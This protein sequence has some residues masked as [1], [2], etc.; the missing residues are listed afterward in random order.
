[1]QKEGCF[2]LMPGRKWSRLIPEA[3]SLLWFPSLVTRHR[4]ASERRAASVL[5]ENT[6]TRKRASLY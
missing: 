2:L 5:V 1:M 6:L 4:H 3:N